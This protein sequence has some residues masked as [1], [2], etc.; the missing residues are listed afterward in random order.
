MASK[1][2]DT[3]ASEAKA[4]AAHQG[5][6][7]EEAKDRVDKPPAKAEKGEPVG[8]DTPSALALAKVGP[9]GD[10]E[11]YAVEKKKHRWG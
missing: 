3:T 11:E 1:K 7:R 8:Q 4:A 9:D 5:E 2:K 10:G 6:G